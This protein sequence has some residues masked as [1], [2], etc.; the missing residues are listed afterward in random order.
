MGGFVPVPGQSVYGAA[1]AGVKLLTEG[2]RSELLG[3]NVRVTV[4]FPGAIGTQITENSGVDLNLESEGVSDLKLIKP[5]EPSK[6]AQIIVDG[7]ERNR[8]RILVGIDSKL[9]DIIYR[10]SPRRA[11]DLINRL[12]KSLLP[13]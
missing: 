11:A 9:M 3:T 2:L 5:M 13:A 4:V 8:Y 7:I 1:K 6:A 12:M 10:V